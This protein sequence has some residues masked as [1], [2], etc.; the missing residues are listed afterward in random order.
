MLR[1]HIG[2]GMEGGFGLAEDTV[3]NEA[4]PVG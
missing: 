4:Q 3:C 2:T 1:G